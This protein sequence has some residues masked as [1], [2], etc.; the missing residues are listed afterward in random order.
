MVERIAD[1]LQADG[2][3][4]WID[5]SAN[6]AGEYWR[7][8]IVDGLL[9][10]QGV[11]AF[12][13]EHSMRDPGACRDELAIAMGLRGLRVVT[14]LLEDE[15]RVN[16]PSHVAEIQWVDLR[17]WTSQG[18]VDSD[19]W[20]RWYAGKYAEL[21][22]IIESASLSETTGELT[23]LRA[24]LGVVVA[25]SKVLL[26]RDGLVVERT[27]VRSRTSSWLVGDDPLML[28]VGGLGTG[29]TTLAASEL[30]LN[31]IAIG[32]AFCNRDSPRGSSSL[33]A[34][35]R[36]DF[37]LAARLPDYRALLL[38]YLRT[39]GSGDT[40]AGEFFQD[41]IVALLR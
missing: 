25:P 10:S 15:S 35:R 28:I 5:T 33:V 17:D 21:R 8:T 41:A 34:V 31:P 6:K 24:R 23:E 30:Q 40:G 11:L 26:L 14:A 2:F 38:E 16:P 13:S 12:L 22:T 4:V 7:R 19:V 36:L 18:D 39:V 27:R 3:T 20:T 1:D 37:A 32:G 9:G 29:K